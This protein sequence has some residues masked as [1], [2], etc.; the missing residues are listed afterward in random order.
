MYILKLI[1]LSYMPW[2]VI[3][4]GF[5]STNISNNQRLLSLS[6]LHSSTILLKSP[7][8]RKNYTLSDFLEIKQNSNFHTFCKVGEI[9]PLI[10]STG[11][12]YL[13]LQIKPVIIKT[14]NFKFENVPFIK[15]PKDVNDK[16][17]KIG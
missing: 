6:N 13:L 9:Q 12:T 14:F 3:F 2:I 7:F 5:I 11:F 10:K 15:I 1:S 4:L 17:K 8:F 16:A